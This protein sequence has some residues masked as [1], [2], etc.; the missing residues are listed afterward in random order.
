MPRLYGPA[1]EELDL[2][3]RAPHHEGIQERVVVF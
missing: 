2:P 3:F 1:L